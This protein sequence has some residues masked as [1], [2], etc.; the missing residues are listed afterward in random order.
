M[1]QSSE[2]VKTHENSR[3]TI[4]EDM[5]MVMGAANMYQNGDGRVSLVFWLSC[6]DDCLKFCGGV[7]VS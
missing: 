1:N 3:K 5:Q 6:K 7:D 2:M 4:I